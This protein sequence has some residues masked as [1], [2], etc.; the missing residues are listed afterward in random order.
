MAENKTRPT[1]A[2]VDAFL[3]AVKPMSK[4]MDAETICAMIERITSEPPALWGPTMIG[5]GLY[6][7]RY[8]SGHSG[9]SFRTGF[10]PRKANLVIYIVD[11]LDTHAALLG[12]L[13]KFRKGKSCLYVNKLADID[14]TVLEALVTESI[15]RMDQKYPR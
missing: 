1:G 14:V 5:F 15:A 7:Y 11:G 3:A 2:D 9:E 6:R 8:E 4:R 10:S 13:G 12:R